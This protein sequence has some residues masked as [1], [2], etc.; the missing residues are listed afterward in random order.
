M[1]DF[2]DAIERYPNLLT[3][4]VTPAGEGMSISFNRR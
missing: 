3:S 1:P 2:L 4:I